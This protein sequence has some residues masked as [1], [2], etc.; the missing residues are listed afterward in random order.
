LSK[1]SVRISSQ[2]FT[3]LIPYKLTEVE[4]SIP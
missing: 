3:I 2:L 1:K 4:L